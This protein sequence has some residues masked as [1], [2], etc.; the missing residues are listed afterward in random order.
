MSTLPDQ[1]ETPDVLAIAGVIGVVISMPLAWL[2]A[3]EPII[4]VD[5]T[6]QTTQTGIESPDGMV[7]LIGVAVLAV[8][9]LVGRY[10]SDGWGYLSVI[11]SL[12]AGLL[13]C[14]ISMIYILDPTSGA[15]G[16]P[17]VLEQLSAGVGLYFAFIGGVLLLAA[18]VLGLFADSDEE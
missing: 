7:V 11:P 17:A 16:S 5:G 3:D 13:A 6:L 1:L 9:I 14:G 18:G 8:I 2:E 12:L 4:D 15:A 10:R